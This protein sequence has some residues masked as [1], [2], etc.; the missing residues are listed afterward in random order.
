MFRTKPCRERIEPLLATFATS[1]TREN[2]PMLED[3]E[4]FTHLRWYPRDDVDNE[5]NASSDDEEEKD[6][7]PLLKHGHRWGVKSLPGVS[8]RMAMRQH[9]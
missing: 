6:H 9:R 4:I 5:E 3:A 8:R 1:L 7:D 2:M